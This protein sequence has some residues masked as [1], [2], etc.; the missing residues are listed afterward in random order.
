MVDV[1]SPLS[2]QRGRP[3]SNRFALAPLT[4]LQSFPDGVLSDDEFNWLVKRAQGGFGLVMTCAAHVHALG[5]GF[6]GQ[7]GVFSERHLEGLTR[8]AAALRAGGAL[9]SVQLYHGGDR[10]PADLVGQPVSASDDPE[11]GA[12]GLAISEVEAIVDAFAEAA[13]RCERAG[14]DGV[15]LHG[16]HGYIINQFLSPQSNRRTDRY[17]G[18]FENRARFLR[19]IIGAIR[20]R[21]GPDF[22]LGLRISPDRFGLG[23]REARDLAAEL[24]TSGTLDYL[25]L[26]LHD[27]RRPPA[28]AGWGDRGLMDWFLDLPRGETRLGLAGHIRSPRDVTDMIE[29]GAD[30]VLLGRAGILHHDFPRRMRDARFEPV[31][32]PVTREYLL[33]EGLGEA[34]VSYLTR[35]PD[36]VDA[37]GSLKNRA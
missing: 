1:F 8:L 31:K 14:F 5:Q 7:L 21:C 15:E 13:V 9:S 17:G 30:F 10:S 18:A 34:F 20:R 11:T 24:F 33:A 4:N 22:Q 28:E 16:A 37:T 27:V 6:Q 35:W 25:D 3:M 29:A 19:E 26:S 32:P 23:M 12:R 36:F 2:F